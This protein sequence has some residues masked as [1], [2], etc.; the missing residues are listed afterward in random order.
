[1]AARSA[2]SCCASNCRRWNRQPPALRWNVWPWPPSATTTCKAG[3]TDA[4]ADLSTK[5][6]G[7]I[8]EPF[9]AHGIGKEGLTDADLLGHVTVLHFWEYR[10]EP[11]KEPYGQVAYLDHLYHQRKDAGLKIYGFAVDS[12]LGDEKTRTAAE[13]SVKRIKAFMNLSYPVLLDS[14]ALLKQFGDPRLLA[15]LCRY[16][17]WSVAMGRSLITTSAITK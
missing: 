16:S 6:L 11:L 12:R 4:L 10:D 5:Y 13:R 9:A 8:V 17:W 14:G 1:M 15:L 3:R 7:H 2:S